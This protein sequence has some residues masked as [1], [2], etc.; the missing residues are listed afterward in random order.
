MDRFG[1]D[2]IG[3]VDAIQI[4]SNGTG[5]RGVLE[6]KRKGDTKNESEGA[7][8]AG[9]SQRQVASRCGAASDG[10]DGRY[11]DT[12]AGTSRGDRTVGGTGGLGALEVWSD[13][14]VIACSLTD[15]PCPIC[16]GTARRQGGRNGDARTGEVEGAVDMDITD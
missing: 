8:R 15:N 6:N 4:R 9:S 12:A 1:L 3:L 16:R 7:R 11:R 2:W 13:P 10:A 14:G 5:R